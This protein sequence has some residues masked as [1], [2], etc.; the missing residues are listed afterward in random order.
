MKTGDTFH[1]NAHTGLRAAAPNRHGRSPSAEQAKLSVKV[2]PT[3]MAKR[4]AAELSLAPCAS[5]LIVI[6]PE[7]TQLTTDVIPSSA[8]NVLASH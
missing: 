6:G 3:A 5:K 2:I 4:T 8:S 1:N 7:H